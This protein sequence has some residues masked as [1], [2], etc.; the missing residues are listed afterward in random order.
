MTAGPAWDFGH[1]GLVGK[2]RAG[3]LLDCRTHDAMPATHREKEP[4]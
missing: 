4:A 2:A 1:V 3:R